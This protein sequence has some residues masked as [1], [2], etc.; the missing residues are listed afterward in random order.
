M[1][2]NGSG[3]LASAAVCSSAWK[4]SGSVPT[5]PSMVICVRFCCQT[6]QHHLVLGQCSGLVHAQYSGRPQRLDRG[7]AAREH[8]AA[9]D[10]PRPKREKYRQH[11]RKLL[12]Q[13][14]HRHRD[15]GQQPLL[16]YLPASA[17]SE[18]SRR[19]PRRRRPPGPPRP[20]CGRSGRSPAAAAWPRARSAAV[21]CRS[22]RVRYALR[23]PA[24]RAT[25]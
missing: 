17:A 8:A 10:S 11:D 24:P 2:S 19:R 25:P 12:G 15:A 14:G 1:G 5:V 6:P 4:P 22:C 18:R 13:D 20:A 9:R 3:L 23:W 7:H 21:P 16:P